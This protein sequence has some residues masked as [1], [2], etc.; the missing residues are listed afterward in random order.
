[1]MP[2]QY[3]LPILP[4]EIM[5]DADLPSLFLYPTKDIADRLQSMLEAELRSQYQCR[6]YLHH[7]RH[8]RSS[9]PPTLV[10]TSNVNIAAT[11]TTDIVTPA[12]RTKIVQWLYECV[13]Y[14]DLSRECVAMAM[15]YVDRLMSSSRTISNRAAA[16][17]VAQAKQDS[18]MYQLIAVSSLF[19]AMKLNSSQSVRSSPID[20]HTLVLISHDSYSAK[21]IIDM[22]QVVLEGLE[23]RVCGPTSLS[24]AYEAIALLTKTIPSNK[25][26]KWRRV[27]SL[28]DFTRLQI[29]MSILDYNTSVL[30]SP[31]TIAL[32]SIMNSMELLDFTM[33]EKRSFS[34]TLMKCTVGIQ[35]DI[36]QS[37]QMERIRK[38]LHNVFDRQSSNIIDRAIL[39]MSA[40]TAS[41]KIAPQNKP[42]SQSLSPTK[43][44]VR[45]DSDIVNFA[46]TKAS[47][48]RHQHKGPRSSSSRNYRRKSNQVGL[49]PV[50][51]RADKNSRHHKSRR[52]P[53]EP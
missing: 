30:R 22:E 26:D 14:L 40:T 3:L 12:L 8:R 42:R 47:Y 23:W 43:S 6:D 31:S 24:I 51:K 39:G 16:A 7:R 35:N 38:E 19:L 1:M 21:E 29:E 37:P 50:L 49:N 32:A 5:T 18:M 11:A 36:F 10:S 20:A 17:T 34:H 9:A 33:K 52:V 45:V 41:E 2:T 13:D 28:L 53:L 44:P 25:A 27:S 4:S 48:S 15:S 46:K